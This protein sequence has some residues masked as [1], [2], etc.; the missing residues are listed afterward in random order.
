MNKQTTNKRHERKITASRLR[1]FIA[2]AA[3]DIAA[4]IFPV[5]VAHVKFSH[6]L[7]SATSKNVCRSR[8]ARLMLDILSGLFLCPDIPAISGCHR[9]FDA[10]LGDDYLGCSNGDSRF[11]INATSKIV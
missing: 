1:R 3:E 4:K 10:L 9:F 6:Y 5:S 11:F 8:R 7:C 2:A